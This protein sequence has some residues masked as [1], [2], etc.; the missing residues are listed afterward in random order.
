MTTLKA[1]T[2]TEIEVRNNGRVVRVPVLN[3]IQVDD[4]VASCARAA[5][6]YPGTEVNVPSK[7]PRGCKPRNYATYGGIQ[8]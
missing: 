5:L 4:T 2:S 3:L 7:Q 6:A 1:V 8:L